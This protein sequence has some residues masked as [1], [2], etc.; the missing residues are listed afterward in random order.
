MRKLFGKNAER[1][2]SIAK[3]NTSQMELIAKI[4]NNLVKK[5]KLIN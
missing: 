3:L 1:M 4:E 5:L 2:D